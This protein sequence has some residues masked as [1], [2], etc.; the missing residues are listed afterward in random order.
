M[1]PDRATNNGGRTMEVV[2]AAPRCQLL[3]IVLMV[4]ML[5]PGMKSSSLLV[6]R[7]IAR[8]IE[9]QESIRKVKLPLTLSVELTSGLRH[10]KQ[11]TNK[12]FLFLC[13]VS[14]TKYQ[15]KTDHIGRKE[16]ISQ[17]ILEVYSFLEKIHLLELSRLSKHHPQLMTKILKRIAAY[18]QRMYP[19]WTLDLL[20]PSQVK[21]PP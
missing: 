11:V 17:S 10:G 12:Q 18:S 14:L 4:A 16:L 9:L 8:T 20:S 1:Q 3:L 21:S 6:R 7:K 5:F 19:S 2:A 15:L 13:F